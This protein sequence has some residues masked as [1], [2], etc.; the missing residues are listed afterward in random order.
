MMEVAPEIDSF[1]DD[2]LYMPSQRSTDS[3]QPQSDANMSQGSTD[4]VNN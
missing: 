2:D 4:Q 3:S 1:D